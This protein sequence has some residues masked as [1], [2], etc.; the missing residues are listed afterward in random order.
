MKSLG[1]GSTKETVGIRSA[2]L[3]KKEIKGESRLEKNRGKKNRI[4]Y[5]GKNGQP[6]KKSK[7]CG[8]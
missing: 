6:G 8:E 4:I 1:G 7:Q 5:V 2:D 3:K